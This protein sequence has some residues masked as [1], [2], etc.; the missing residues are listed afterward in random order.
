[1]D[2]RPVDQVV[3]GVGDQAKEGAAEQ[4]VAGASGQ[5]WL[6]HKNNNAGQKEEVEQTG[7]QPVCLLPHERAELL[8]VEVAAEPAE[9][10]HVQWEE[11]QEG[12]EVEF[13]K[14][15]KQGKVIIICAG[16]N[17]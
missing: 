14:G 15:H 16:R 2:D 12:D 11:R 6:H 13:E 4:N 5:R 3:G 17:R 10:E 9:P 7:G 1:M 8:A